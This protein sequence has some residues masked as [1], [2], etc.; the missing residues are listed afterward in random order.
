MFSF[1]TNI[2]DEWVYFKTKNG[3]LYCCDALDFMRVL[4]R[5]VFDLVLTDPPYGIGIHKMGFT[6][7]GRSGRGLAKKTEFSLYDDQRLSCDYF[8]EM[9]RVS[10]NQI[11]WG[12][13]YYL[14]CLYPTR[15]MLVWFKRD[16]LPIRSFSDCEIAWTSFDRVSMVFNCRWDGF[17]RDSREPKTGHPTQ[18]ALEVFKW[19]VFEFSS[20]D[21]IIFDPFIGSGTTAEAC[22]LL[23]RRWVG[24]EINPEYCEMVKN[25]LAGFV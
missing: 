4:S 9:M 13:N 18:K 15:C 25:R 5:E 11:I 7:G 1:C 20:E 17:I 23:G 10:K 24:V 8:V 3:V 6:K 14:D 22:E 21:D 16:R 2:P 12:G 19:C